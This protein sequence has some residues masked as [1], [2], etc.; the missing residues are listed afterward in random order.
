MLFVPVTKLYRA[1]CMAKGD[2]KEIHVV[3]FA[4]LKC[5]AYVVLKTNPGSVA[6]IKGKVLHT[7]TL[8]VFRRLFLS[9]HGS[10][11][12]FAVGLRPLL[13]F[14][15]CHLKGHYGGI[16]LFLIRIDAKFQIYPLT[17]GIVETE[18]KDKWR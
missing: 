8:L 13:R 7:K 17:I 5:Y 4:I 10:I 16:L 14:Y 6:K 9:F 12:G 15:R 2:T 3:E 11:V 18:N 1:R